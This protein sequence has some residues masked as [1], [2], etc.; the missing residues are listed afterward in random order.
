MVRLS[1]FDRPHILVAS[2]ALLALAGCGPGQSLT[3]P[4]VGAGA[5]TSSLAPRVVQRGTVPI[6]WTQ[7]SPPAAFTTNESVVAGPDRNMWFGNA[8]PVGGLLRVTMAGAMTLFPLHYACGQATPCVFQSGYGM[9]VGSDGKI[10]LGGSNHNYADNKN[11]IGVVTTAGKLTVYELPS[12]DEI[13]N[14]ALIL[15]PD[16]NIWFGEVSHIGKITP[17]GKITE[18]ALPANSGYFSGLAAGADGNVWFARGTLGKIVPSTGRVTLYPAVTGGPAIAPGSGGDLYV[19]SGQGFSL[20]Q[21]TTAGRA[22]GLSP[23]DP[24]GISNVPAGIIRGPDG[25]PWFASGGKAPSIGEFNPIDDSLTNYVPPFFTGTNGEVFEL[26]LGP[27]GNI[28]APEFY[29]NKI[30]VYII[31]TL[32][33]SPRS[34]TLPVGGSA[35]LTVKEPGTSKWTAFSAAPKTCS[36]AVTKAADAFVVKATGAG[37]TSI[38]IEDAIG[39]STAIPCDAL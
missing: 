14:N 4:L 25:N 16:H 37:K 34:V 8:G 12:G 18:Y 2:V 7:F 36:V 38:T 27:D 39:N 28:W 11:T 9:A 20:L 13:F 35:T 29:T 31:K 30:D 22:V 10:Y 21:V 33:V 23:T 32:V 19:S 24:Y 3:P 26:A 17:A 6:M 1:P 5:E 15:G